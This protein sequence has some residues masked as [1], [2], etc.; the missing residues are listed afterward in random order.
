MLLGRVVKSNSHVDYVVQIFAPG[1]VASPP[2]PEDY[3]F[4]SFVRIAVDGGDSLIGVIYDTLLLN[5]S[6]GTLGP[7]LS[8]E[9]ERGTFAPDYLPETM[10]VVGVAVL[11]LRSETPR[12][13]VYRQGVPPLAAR[14]GAEAHLLSDSDS[15]FVAFHRGESGPVVAYLPRLAAMGN[16]AMPELLNGLL[17]RLIA[18]FPDNAATLSVL[19]TNLDWTSRLVR[20][21]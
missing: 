17:G 10:T 8:G 20:H 3:A 21:A 19:Q 13:I 2:R 7:R 12:G 6:Y 16:P 11:G 9:P 5:P 4:G 14:V 18:A 15:E 1:E